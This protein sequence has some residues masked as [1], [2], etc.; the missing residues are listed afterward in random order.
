MYRADCNDDTILLRSLAIASCCHP[1]HRTS[2]PQL[3][4]RVTAPRCTSPMPHHSRARPQ[5]CQAE[6]CPTSVFSPSSPLSVSRVPLVP[7]CVA[8]CSKL[9]SDTLSEAVAAVLKNSAEK[10]RG[11]VETIE[12]Q[13]ALK[14]YDPN[15]DKRFSGTVR[16][17]Y[18]PNWERMTT[19]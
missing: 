2:Y 13:I 5:R 7:M 17:P 6:S 9:S 14:N 12:L 1:P 8:C 15:K 3:S 4:L 16:L 10:K 11:F 19:S 18:P